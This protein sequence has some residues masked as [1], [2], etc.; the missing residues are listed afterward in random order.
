MTRTTTAADMVGTLELRMK[1]AQEAVQRLARSLLKE[2]SEFNPAYDLAWSSGEVSSA[3]EFNCLALLHNIC[4]SLGDELSDEELMKRLLDYTHDAMVRSA[5]EDNSTGPMH[6]IV[7]RATH[8]QWV[9]L[10]RDLG[11][12]RR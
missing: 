4:M 3:A 11:G 6:N 8:K 12:D 9:R 5:D 10:Y 2:G 7:A 1:M